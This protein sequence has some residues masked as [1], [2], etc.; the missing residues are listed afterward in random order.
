MW[1]DGLETDL[2]LIEML[3]ESKIPTCFALSP[4]RYKNKNLAND[5][6]DSKYGN[7][8][9]KNDI[10][11]YSHFEICN[12]TMNHY[13]LKFLDKNQTKNEIETSHEM[14][15]VIFQKEIKGF[16]YPYGSKNEFC[17]EILSNLNYTYARTTNSKNSFLDLKPTYKWNEKNLLSLLGI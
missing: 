17:D 16:C 6:R 1:D 3:E 2:K 5:H 7:L 11:K 14:L 9:S 4:N 10:L 13:D 8:I 15:E 12:H